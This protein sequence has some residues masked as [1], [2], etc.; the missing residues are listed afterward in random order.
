MQLSNLLR[1]ERVKSY[2]K[3]KL[4]EAAFKFYE[5]MLKTQIYD[6]GKTK[7]ITLPLSVNALEDSNYYPGADV[8]ARAADAGIDLESIVSDMYCQLMEIGWDNADWHTDGDIATID[9][10]V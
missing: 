8:M 2:Q 9:L 3:T 1:P 10:E 5:K 7:G 4:E 6:L